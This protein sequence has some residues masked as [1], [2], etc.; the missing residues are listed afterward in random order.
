MERSPP[1]KTERLIPESQLRVAIREI[2]AEM[3]GVNATVQSLGQWYYTEQAYPLLGFKSV[4]Q[5]REMVRSGI[6]RVGHE[7]RDVRSPK[8]QVP[9]YQF[10]IEKCEARLAL[11]PEKRRGKKIA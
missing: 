7:V 2:L 11:P 6:L 4:K 10:H 1:Y 8:S 5:L 3:L 9:R